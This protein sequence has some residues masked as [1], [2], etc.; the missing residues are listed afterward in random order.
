MLNR[1]VASAKAS[2][3][4]PWL[5]VFFAFG[6][7]MCAV[8]IALLLFPGTALDP[9]WRL[10]PDAHAVFETIGAWSMAIMLIVGAACCFAAIGLWRGALWGTRVALIILTVNMVGDLINTVV[11]H[12]YRALVGLPVAAAMIFYLV[13]K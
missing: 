7:S 10:N 5:A 4:H 3:P 2:L 13:R 9:L 12:D 6:A 11:R 1:N 8:T